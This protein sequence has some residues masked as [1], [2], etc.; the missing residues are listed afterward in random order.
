[1]RNLIH[2][3][4]FAK[5]Q[6]CFFF[7]WTWNTIDMQ[8]LLHWQ[9]KEINFGFYGEQNKN[10]SSICCCFEQFNIIH[11]VKLYCCQISIFEEI[12]S[13]TILWFIELLHE[14]MIS[15]TFL[16]FL[17][18][19]NFYPVFHYRCLILFNLNYSNCL[20]FFTEIDKSFSV[21]LGF[22][23]CSFSFRFSLQKSNQSS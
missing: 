22:V 6:A 17:V 20:L 23:C 9:M 13:G 21:K 4:C 12:W 7:S 11:Q 19:F 2:S 18:L 1:M 5:S 3:I 14:L 16:V 10:L 15:F 8:Y